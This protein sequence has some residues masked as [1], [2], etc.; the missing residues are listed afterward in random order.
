MNILSD[1]QQLILNYVKEGKNVI[2]DAVAGTGKTTMILS[3]AAELLDLKIVQFTYNSSLKEDVRKR[4]KETGLNNIEIHTFHSFMKAYYSETGFGDSDMRKVLSKDLSPYRTIP[5]FD[6]LVLDESQD[7][8]FLYF[9]FIG[10]VFRDAGLSAQIL[11]LG[12]YMQGLYDFKGADTRF[13]TM[14]EQ[15]WSDFQYLKTQEFQ[16]CTMKMS[17]RIT[18]QMCSFVNDIMLGEPRM[19]ACRD[20]PSILY[21][22]YPMYDALKVIYGEILRLFEKG[23]IPDDIFILANSVKGTNSKIAQLENSLVER[24]I[25]CHVPMIDGDKIDDRV[26]GGKVVFST[27]HCSKGRQRKYVFIVGF[28]HMS[29]RYQTRDLPE[30][31]CPNTLYVGATRALE[32]LCLI[33]NDARDVDR[34]L[35]FLKKSHIEMK[36]TNYIEFRGMHKSIFKDAPLNEQFK[37]ITPTELI[38]FIPDSVIDDLSVLLDKIFIP[39]DDSKIDEIDINSIVETKDGLFEEVSDLN[40]IAIPAIYYDHLKKESDQFQKSVLL[41][42]ID[43]YMTAVKE[44]EHI[45]LRKLV[46]DIPEEISSL[47][48]YLYVANVLTAVQEKLYFKVKQINKTDYNW[49]DPKK[50]S[51]CLKRFKEVVGKDCENFLPRIEETIIH[52]NNDDLHE[53]ID[54]FLKVAAPTLP[55]IRFAARIDTIT[56]TT[57]WEI[58]CTKTLSTDHKLQVIIYAWLMRM[59]HSKPD[60]DS[61]K[62]FKLFNIRSG[63]ILR[64]EASMDELNHIMLTLLKIKYQERVVKTDEDFINECRGYLASI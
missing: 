53:K 55:K 11:I 23:A 61:K 44:N 4:A 10:K 32:R 50:I 48:D 1:E 33:E 2:V 30:D 18:N 16:L 43:D 64:L 5:K 37:K 29:M 57:V 7:M 21:I 46:N 12:D 40:G 31:R 14:A 26:I 13:L 36:Q 22:R 38:K 52:Y 56:K 24:G 25:P 27:F 51:K 45:Y 15:I 49:L 35:K 47:Q 59:R 20:G 3:I 62:V 19:K 6:I 63:E 42:V 28:D 9:Q 34:P 58:K 39:D 17:F 60:K 41:E 54:H 8:S